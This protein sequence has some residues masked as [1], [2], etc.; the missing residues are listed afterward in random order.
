MIAL[1]LLCNVP[2]DLEHI[3]ETCSNAV[4]AS[5][6][7]HMFT[8]YFFINLIN[9]FLFMNRNTEI[10]INMV[11]KI[12]SDKLKNMTYLQK[13]KCKSKKLQQISELQIK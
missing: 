13:N 9:R 8:A 12:V 11:Q 3:F 2:Q 7:H 1:C 5:N 4:V 10:T 6:W